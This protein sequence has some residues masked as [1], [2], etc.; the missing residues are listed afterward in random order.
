MIKAA[1]GC[2]RNKIQKIPKKLQIDIYALSIYIQ[3][4]FGNGIVNDLIT[5]NPKKVAKQTCILSANDLK[6]TYCCTLLHSLVP[7]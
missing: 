3:W 4:H 7:A 6:F 5:K 2:A 1:R